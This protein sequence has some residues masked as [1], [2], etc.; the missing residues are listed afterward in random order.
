MTLDTTDL[1]PGTLCPKNLSLEKLR[2]T[3]MDEEHTHTIELNLSKLHQDVPIFEQIS[4]DVF[5][6]DYIMP[7]KELDIDKDMFQIPININYED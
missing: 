6:A 7:K 3:L 4:T 5:L 2:V 1:K